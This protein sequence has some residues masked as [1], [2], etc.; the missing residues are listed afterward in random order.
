MA[1]VDLVSSGQ[2]LV[3]NTGA[4]YNFAF[5]TPVS[6]DGSPHLTML[7]VQLDLTLGG[8][9]AVTSTLSN[10]TVSYTHLTLPTIYSV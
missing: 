6:Q 7:G 4:S 5:D 2:T 3:S 8:A 10:L 1:Y 9:A